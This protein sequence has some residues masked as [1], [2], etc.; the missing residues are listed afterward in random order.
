[1]HEKFQRCAG[2]D[3]AE[4]LPNQSHDGQDGEQRKSIRHADQSFGD[5][6]GVIEQWQAIALRIKPTQHRGPNG[7]PTLGTSS[8]QLNPFDVKSTVTTHQGLR[9]PAATKFLWWG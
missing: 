4:S 8:F 3:L 6:M 2:R 1:L 7:L 5:P 9:Q